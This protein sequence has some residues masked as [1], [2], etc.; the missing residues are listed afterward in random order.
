M[1]IH[2]DEFHL[3][4]I[5]LMFMRETMAVKY[6]VESFP[7]LVLIRQPPQ[8]GLD[9]GSKS[10]RFHVTKQVFDEMIKLWSV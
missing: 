10:G 5:F 7:L 4:M 6:E 8:G 2:R 9:C 1:D 3:D